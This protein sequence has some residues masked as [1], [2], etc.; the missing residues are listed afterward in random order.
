MRY[1]L[2]INT[3]QYDIRSSMFIIRVYDFLKLLIE[4]NTKKPCTI[5]NKNMYE[6]SKSNSIRITYEEVHVTK[7]RFRVNWVKK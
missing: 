6:D 2:T 4:L 5:S 1:L 7:I 3:K